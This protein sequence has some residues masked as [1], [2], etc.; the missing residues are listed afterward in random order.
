[1]M[2]E[3]ENGLVFVLVRQFW[4]V[5]SVERNR[6]SRRPS[7]G[8]LQG[9]SQ[10]VARLEGHVIGRGLGVSVSVCASV[11]ECVRAKTKDAWADVDNPGTE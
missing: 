2:R 10:G 6:P 9:A 4:E 1:M 3:E 8:G 5:V 7:Q 11:C